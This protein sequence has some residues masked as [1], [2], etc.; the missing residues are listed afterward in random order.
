MCS[1][2]GPW[3]GD[4]GQGAVWL[5]VCT[6]GY[7]STLVYQEAPSCACCCF[8]GGE[9]VATVWGEPSA[10]QQERRDATKGGQLPD[11]GESPVGQG[12]LHVQRGE[13]NRSVAG[14]RLGWGHRAQASLCCCGGARGASP[15]PRTL[16]LQELLDCQDPVPGGFRAS[17]PAGFL[18]TCRP[19][20]HT[21]LSLVSSCLWWASDCSKSGEGLL[22]PSPRCEGGPGLLCTLPSPCALL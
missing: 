14:R 21:D 2:S 19:C 12:D 22:L 18:L 3:W 13:L 4:A 10:K 17:S 16:C 5:Q 15:P 1:A 6:D 8:V 20:L 11:H 9:A 7:S